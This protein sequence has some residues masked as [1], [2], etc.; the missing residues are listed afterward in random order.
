MTTPYPD[1]VALHEPAWRR[2]SRSANGSN[3][4][5]CVEV[6]FVGDGVAIRDS[7]TSVTMPRGLGITLHDWTAFIATIRLDNS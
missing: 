5:N 4:S 2:S 7:K 1:S 3:G 6:A